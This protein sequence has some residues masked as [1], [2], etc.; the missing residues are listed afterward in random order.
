MSKIA[1]IDYDAGNTMSV[2]N[3]LKFLGYEVE[4]SNDPAVL[5]KADHVVFPGVGAYADCMNKV[6]EYKLIDPIKEIIKATASS[7]EVSIQVGKIADGRA[8]V[9]CTYRG[10][11]KIYL[12]N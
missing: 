7:P 6:R 5:Y 12:I 4:L 9:T 10:Q 3:A 2:M 8:T 1:V 11:K